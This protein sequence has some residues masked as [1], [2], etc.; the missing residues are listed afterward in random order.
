MD[1]LPSLVVSRYQ[2]M[3]EG[4]LLLLSELYHGLPT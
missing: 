4:G 1:Y 3:V 2:V